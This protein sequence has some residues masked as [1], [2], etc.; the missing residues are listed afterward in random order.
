MLTWRLKTEA[1]M[2]QNQPSNNSFSGYRPPT[3]TP[4]SVLPT[5]G[6]DDKPIPAIQPQA[7]LETRQNFLDPSLLTSF[8]NTGAVAGNMGTMYGSMLP[9][10]RDFMMAQTSP[11]LNQMEQGFMAASTENSRKT[12]EDLLQRQE[13]QYELMPFHSELPRA[14]GELQ[15][16]MNRDLLQQ[17]SQLAMARQSIGAQM[18]PMAFQGMHQAMDVGPNLVE[19]L[20]NLATN[21]YS[22][23]YQIPL[24]VYSQLPFV[25]PTVV[26]QSGGG[27]GI[28][29]A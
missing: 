14:Q 22:A 18:A 15:A 13:A 11:R 28:G 16:Q 4:G 17:G 29:K 20:F 26:Q 23:P 25:A 21:A 19:R 7:S 3:F 8:Y 12:L 6:P 1:T 24:Q 27:G 5:S 10:M 2:Q 9:Q